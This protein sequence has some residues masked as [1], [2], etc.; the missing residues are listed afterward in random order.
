MKKIS[1][2]I[3][4]RQDGVDINPVALDSLDTLCCQL[5]L[6]MIFRFVYLL[7]VN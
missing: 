2:Q 7:K 4:C 1:I 6:A 3:V 5:G